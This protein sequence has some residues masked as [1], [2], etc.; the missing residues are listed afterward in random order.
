VSI[1]EG[2]MVRHI[3]CALIWFSGL[4][5]STGAHA[6]TPVATSTRSQSL[7]AYLLV[8]GKTTDRA[9][10]GAYASALP[11]IYAE[12]NAH[13]LAIG[14]AGRG[15]TWLEGP[16][17]DRSV[18]L[19]KFPSADQIDRFWWG[20]SYRAAIRKRD[21][22]GVFSV[23][24]VQGI[25]ALPFEGI[26]TGYLIIMTAQRDP[27]AAQS[28]LAAQA[29]R[30]FSEGVVASGGIMMTAN[31]AGGFSSLEG[32]SVFDRYAVAMWPSVGAR[33]AYLA[34]PPARRAAMLRQRLGLSVVAAAN[35]V[36]QN[37][38]PPAATSQSPPQ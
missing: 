9:K 6:Q 22:A 25:T 21:R 38:T 4:L 37:Q 16:W 28:A 12:N 36:S 3:I 18:I 23:V 19:A 35:G 30:I 5:G 24:S 2:F 11:P 29:A 32:D 20:D 14:A 10:I 1:R 8:V 27:S 26:G 7:P 34:S 33:D 31:E 13:Y 15:V 17:R